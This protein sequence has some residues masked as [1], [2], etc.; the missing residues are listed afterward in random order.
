MSKL[1][2][3]Y[4]Q[5]SYDIVTTGA[6][7]EVPTSKPA[8]FTYADGGGVTTDSAA[9]NLIQKG[10][11]A[12]IAPDSKNSEGGSFYLSSKV[13]VSETNE[14]LHVKMDSGY[15][16]V[17]PKDQDFSKETLKVFVDHIEDELGTELV[18][19]EDSDE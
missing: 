3:A 2:D 11:F 12:L 7:V 13:L 18:L 14:F 9:R 1:E 10:D 4:S 5:T 8:I 17:F 16:R 19:E 15:V 6:G